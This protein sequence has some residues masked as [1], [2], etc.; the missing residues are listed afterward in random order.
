MRERILTALDAPRGWGSSAEHI[1]KATG[2]PDAERILLELAATGF[3]D[4]TPEPGGWRCQ[5]ARH[6]G[7]ARIQLKVTE[8]A[9]FQ[10]F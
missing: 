8:R 6:E 1:A 2:V 7:K 3:A 5:T 10:A 9:D 4:F